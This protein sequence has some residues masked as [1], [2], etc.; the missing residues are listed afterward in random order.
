MGLIHDQTRNKQCLAQVRR[1]SGLHTT[2]RWY[3]TSRQ[4]V[5][6]VHET[7]CCRLPYCTTESFAS[8]LWACLDQLRT[9]KCR[10]TPPPGDGH[11]KGRA[12]AHEPNGR[13]LSISSLW[14]CQTNTCL[15]LMQYWRI[16]TTMHC[17]VWKL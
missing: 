17:K 14:T 13:R 3:A 1:S 6:L 5:C 10:T 9:D 7:S 16:L 12:A 4:P 2:V 8:S 15:K 11:D